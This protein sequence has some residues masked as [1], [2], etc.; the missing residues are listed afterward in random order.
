MLE[1]FRLDPRWGA[2][3]E[4]VRDNVEASCSDDRSQAKQEMGETPPLGLR[5][6]LRRPRSTVF[7]LLVSEAAS[8]GLLDTE[9]LED[10]KAA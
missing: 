1:G 10:L 4:E 3:W 8:E 6:A 5:E 9:T 7:D 2:Y